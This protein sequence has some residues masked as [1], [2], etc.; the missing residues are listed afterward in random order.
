[1]SSKANTARRQTHELILSKTKQFDYRTQIGEQLYL[2]TSTRSDIS[3]T[4]SAHA[5]SVHDST[6]RHVKAVW[7]GLLYL[8]STTNTEVRYNQVKVLLVEAFLDSDK[9]GCNQSW[10][11]TSRTPV[12]IISSPIFSK[13]NRQSIIELSSAEA[14]N[15]VL[16]TTARKI[17]RIQRFCWDLHFKAQLNECA[18]IPMISLSTDISAAL[19]IT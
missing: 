13:S 19:A 11:S 12:T 5:R 3:F 7:G 2:A 16:S 6:D 17:S 15:T 14:E 10:R 18:F 9:A 8:S 1:M 4:V